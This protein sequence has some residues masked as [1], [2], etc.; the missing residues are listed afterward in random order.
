MLTRRHFLAISGASVLMPGPGLAATGIETLG[1][2]AFG[3]Y[4]RLTVPNAIASTVSRPQITAIIETV[5]R[6]FSPYREDSELTAIN[7]ADTRDWLPVS[8]AFNA[9]LGHALQIAHRSG[10]TF[11][12]T[13]GPVVARYGFGPIEADAWG[14]Y[15]QIGSGDNRVRKNDPGLSLDLCGVAKGYALA[16]MAANL[17]RQGLTDFLL[18]LGGELMARGVHPSGRDWQAGVEGPDGQ[19]ALGVRLDGRAIATSGIA[20]QSYGLPGQEISHIINP[21]TQRPVSGATFSVTVLDHDAASAD[22]WATALMA[23]PFEKAIE[24]AELFDIDALV[25]VRDGNK[26]RALTSGNFADFLLT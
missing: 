16:A 21:L 19:L 24:T 1:G 6:V 23:M 9:V 22:G 8:S 13:I 5:D 12:P 7:R 14:N 11:D 20:A 2:P 3:T 18:D 26:V 4:W 25:L 15:A 17:E 10:G